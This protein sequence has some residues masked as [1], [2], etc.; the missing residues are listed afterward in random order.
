[1]TIDSGGSLYVSD[2]TDCNC[3]FVFSNTA[4]GT[5]SPLR[6]IQGNRTQ[7]NDPVAIAVDGPGNLYV[8]DHF[9]AY[10]NA[11]ATGGAQINVFPLVPP[12]T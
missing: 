12:E 2:Q 3:V 7:I 8:A 4:S 6:T 5:A 1:M 9:G 11:P 10:P